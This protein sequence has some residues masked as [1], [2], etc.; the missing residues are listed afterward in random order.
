MRKRGDNWPS[1]SRRVV[2]SALAHT[3]YS[4]ERIDRRPSGCEWCARMCADYCRTQHAFASVSWQQGYNEHT[5]QPPASP[6]LCYEHPTR[7]LHESISPQ[8]ASHSLAW[9]RMY[10]CASLAAAATTVISYI[11]HSLPPLALVRTR[12]IP[13]TTFTLRHAIAHAFTSSA[14]LCPFYNTPSFLLYF[15]YSCRLAFNS[16]L[17]THSRSFASFSALFYAPNA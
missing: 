15:P 5:R 8:R 12:T 1:D 9:P 13:P 2:R 7:P 3:L 11:S 16:L 4:S 14:F 10:V 17:P 6:P